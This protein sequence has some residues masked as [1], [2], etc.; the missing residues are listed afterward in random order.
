LYL[1]VRHHRLLTGDT[2]AHTFVRFGIG[3]PPGGTG[4]VKRVTRGLAPSSAESIRFE[5]T[6]DAFFELI[7]VPDT[8]DT[9]VD[10]SG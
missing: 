3:A 7:G 8:D 4:F 9:G 10:R 6:R 5:E 2:W 1:R